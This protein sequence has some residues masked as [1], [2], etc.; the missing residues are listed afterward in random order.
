MG[1]HPDSGFDPRRFCDVGTGAQPSGHGGGQGVDYSGTGAA[2]FRQQRRFTLSLLERPPP[3]AAE[4]VNQDPPNKFAVIQFAVVD[5]LF[6]DPG[7]SVAIGRGRDRQA[8]AAASNYPGNCRRTRFST[9][10]LVG[11]EHRLMQ[12]GATGQFGLGQSRSLSEFPQS[13]T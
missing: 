5:Q 13:A 4:R 8:M 6:N 2:R 9:T 7:K 3:V 1:Q 10:R 11:A 12:A